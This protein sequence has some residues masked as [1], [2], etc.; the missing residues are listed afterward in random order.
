MEYLGGLVVE[1]IGNLAGD[2]LWSDAPD[3]F[4][5]PY[6]LIVVVGVGY[7]YGRWG[8]GVGLQWGG[9]DMVVLWVLW[10]LFELFGR[11]F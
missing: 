8:G 1:V 11:W 4:D 9:V 7:F 5:A 3:E 10:C 6:D 2:E